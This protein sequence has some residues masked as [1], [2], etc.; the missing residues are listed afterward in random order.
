MTTTMTLYTVELELNEAHAESVFLAPSEEAAI[1]H[2]RKWGVING[3]P[4][5][6][7]WTLWRN[8]PRELDDDGTVAEAGSYHYVDDGE[9]V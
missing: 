3:W 5:G 2:A 1:I 7:T 6:A 8:H 9:V 4:K